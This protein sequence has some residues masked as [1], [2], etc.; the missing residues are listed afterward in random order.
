M[1]TKSQRHYRKHRAERC[2]KARAKYAENKDKEQARRRAAMEADPERVRS[3]W[4]KYA[5]ANPEKV[6]EKVRRYDIENADKRKAWRDAH[7]DQLA[8]TAARWDAENRDK[9]KA[10]H[11]ERQADDVNYRLRRALRARLKTALRKN[12]KNTSAVTALGCTL[13]EFRAHLERQFSAGM[14]WDNYGRGGWHIDHVRELVLFDLTDP[15]EAA[16][17]CHY[18][19]LQ[20]L[21]Q[22]Q[23]I[24]KGAHV[25]WTRERNGVY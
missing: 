21:W 4:R 12:Y 14:S 7:K 19:N 23:N 15:A 16:A 2:A 1:E 9:R 24:S 6:R 3:Y 5:A 18:T 8:A 25:R 11:H 17:A 20:P 13:D 10:R 22:A